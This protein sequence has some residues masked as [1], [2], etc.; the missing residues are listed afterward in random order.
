MTRIHR[1]VKWAAASITAVMVGAS[2]MGIATAAST[3]AGD[4][5]NIQVS[6]GVT[7][8]CSLAY[9][10]GSPG[11]LYGVSAGHC[12]DPD[13]LGGQPTRITTGS[14]SVLW[15]AQNGPIQYKS[16]VGGL[17]PGATVTDYSV[18]PLSPGVSDTGTVTSAPAV[19]IR[20]VDQ[21]LAQVATAPRARVGAPVPVSSVAVGDMVCKDG[22]STGRT[23]GP[24]LS[25]NAATGDIF[26]LIPA[27]SG[28]SGAA[29]TVNRAGVLHPIGILSSGTPVLFNMFDSTTQAL[30]VSGHR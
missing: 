21:F 23:C 9:V 2:M 29:L 4:Q 8:K 19:G 15:T 13:T 17:G 11:S 30:E 24:V 6:N 18:F 5:I 16:E 26:A 10:A 7:A 12:V 3:H 25:V 27:I 20:E 22:A 1:T 28:D 14:G